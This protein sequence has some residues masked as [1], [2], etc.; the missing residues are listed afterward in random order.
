MKCPKCGSENGVIVDS[1]PWK[2]ITRRRRE[3]YNC[4]ERWST[5][6]ILAKDYRLICRIKQEVLALRSFEEEQ[7]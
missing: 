1:R 2:D 3:C 6:E 7:E 4:G 5:R